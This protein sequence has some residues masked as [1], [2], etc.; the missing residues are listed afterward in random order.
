[1]KI[2]NELMLSGRTID[3]RRAYEIGMVNKVVK[4]DELLATARR[5]AMLL[6][7]VSSLAI[8]LMKESLHATYEIMGLRSAIARNADLSAILDGSRTPEFQEFERI[9]LS[10][11]LRAALAWRDRQFDELQGQDHA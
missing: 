6:A 8:R 2:A 11:G 3:A 5:E 9:R 10:E 4:P 7:R 1:M